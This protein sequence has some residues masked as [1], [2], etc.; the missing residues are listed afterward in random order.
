MNH[1]LIQSFIEPVDCSACWMFIWTWPR[2]YRK[3]AWDFGGWNNLPL[4]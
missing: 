3:E 1:T 4:L 2:N